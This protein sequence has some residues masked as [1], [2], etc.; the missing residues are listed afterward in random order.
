M[1]VLKHKKLNGETIYTEMTRS[2][3]ETDL[4]NRVK[5]LNVKLEKAIMCDDKKKIKKTLEITNELYE[6][7]NSLFNPVKDKRKFIREYKLNG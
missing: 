2:F 5:E 6:V 3:F 1:I 4:K 7:A